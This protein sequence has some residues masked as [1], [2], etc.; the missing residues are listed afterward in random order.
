[1]KKK[2]KKKSLARP[3]G[4]LGQ[5]FCC[6]VA[7]AHLDQ[8]GTIRVCRKKRFPPWMEGSVANLRCVKTRCIGS[9]F[10]V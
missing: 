3:P 6:F 9:R 7:V 4:S 8:S 5:N 1:M 2:K 10:D